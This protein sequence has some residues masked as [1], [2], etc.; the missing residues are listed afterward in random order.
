M[1][2]IEISLSLS[3]KLVDLIEFVQIFA[4][5]R[6]ATKSPFLVNFLFE[7]SSM[8]SCLF[9]F[10]LFSSQSHGVDMISCSSWYCICSIVEYFVNSVVS[11]LYL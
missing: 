8:W 11:I 1:K 5:R 9:P 2:S 10:S 6:A 4:I 3:M 7:Y